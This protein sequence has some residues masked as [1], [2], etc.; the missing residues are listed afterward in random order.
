MMTTGSSSD[1]SVDGGTE[2]AWMLRA[3]LGAFVSPSSGPLTGQSELV[4]YSRIDTVA[5]HLQ[6]IKAS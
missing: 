3:C 1:F 2:D 6:T 5:R 4:R